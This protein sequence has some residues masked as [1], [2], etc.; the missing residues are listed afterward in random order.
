MESSILLFKPKP[1]GVL[2]AAIVILP[3]S[4]L[5]G[6]RAVVH[7]GKLRWMMRPPTS[8]G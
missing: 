8:K 5:L 2:V 4:V 3:L 7:L 1:E 6:W